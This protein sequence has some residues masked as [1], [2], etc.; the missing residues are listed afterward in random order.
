MTEDRLRTLLDEALPNPPSNLGPPTM[1]AIRAGVRRR[2]LVA[3]AAVAALVLIATTTFALMV[4]GDGWFAQP[5]GPPSPTANPDAT[6]TIQPL[7]A[8]RWTIAKLERDGVTL[9]VMEDQPGRDQCTE[10]P[11]VPTVFDR[12]DDVVLLLYAASNERPCFPLTTVR[13][14]EPLGDRPLVDGI[15]AQPKPVVP[16]QI[17][18]RPTYP[19]GLKVGGEGGVINAPAPTWNTIYEGR[20]GYFVTISAR[21]TTPSPYPV[22]VTERVTIAGRDMGLYRFGSTDPAVEATRGAIWE[23]DGWTLDVSIIEAGSNPRA[24]LLQILNGLVWS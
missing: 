4:R 7:L 16:A 13:L 19:A 12:P 24:E 20:S 14:R 22:T 8:Q 15:D 3:S 18:P 1:E 17:L 11:R 5:V 9:L 10:E 6:P 2:R 23:E 21:R